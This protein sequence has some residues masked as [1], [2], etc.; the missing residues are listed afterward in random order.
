MSLQVD[1]FKNAKFKGFSTMLEA[2]TF[3]GMQNSNNSNSK[4]ERPKSTKP[5]AKRKAAPPAQAAKQAPPRKRPRPAKKQ[6]P[7]QGEEKTF[8]ISVQIAFD[9]GARGNPGPAGAGSEVIIVERNAQGAQKAR[10]KV[11]LRKF[12]GPSATCNA[13][14]WTGVLSGLEQAVEAVDNFLKNNEGSRPLVDIQVQGDS[15]LVVRQ[16]KGEYQV[17][18][19]NLRKIYNK[20]QGTLSKLKKMAG[21]LQISYQHVYRSDNQ[22][23]DRKLM[24]GGSCLYV[25]VFNGNCPNFI[26]CLSGLA[27][28]AMDGQRSWITVTEDTSDDSDGSSDDEKPSSGGIVYVDV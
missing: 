28:E 13:A 27:N 25:L 11:H 24:I 7:S 8:S 16:L 3:C 23:A 19:P 4:E 22:I 12:L 2:Q 1:G 6:V 15:Q 21:S 17:K 26:V 14:E 18:N 10:R 5:V 9:G 20:F